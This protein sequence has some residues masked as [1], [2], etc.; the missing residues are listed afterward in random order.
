MNQKK[1]IRDF[2]RLSVELT[3]EQHTDLKTAAS[4]RGMTIKDFVNHIIK[5]YVDHGS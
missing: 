1:T 3:K 4:M 2:K 5:Y